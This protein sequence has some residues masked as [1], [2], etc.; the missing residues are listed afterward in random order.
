MFLWADNFQ[1]LH[2]LFSSWCFPVLHSDMGE[3]A[4]P[5][6][7]QTCEKTKAVLYIKAN[8]DF[9]PSFLLTLEL[10]PSHG[11]ASLESVTVQGWT[12]C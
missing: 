5:F 7:L 9:F 2:Q 8:S 6:C 3:G 4:F 1:G 11:G 10:A 12:P